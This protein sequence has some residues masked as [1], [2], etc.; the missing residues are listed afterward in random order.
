M[1]LKK[2]NYDEVKEQLAP[3]L[4][5]YD[6]QEELTHGSQC[7]LYGETAILLRIEGS[8]LVVVALAGKLAQTAKAL[9]CHALLSDHIRAIRFHT[10]RIA[11][12]RFLRSHGIPVELWE[13]RENEYVL[14][15]KCGR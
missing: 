12:Q 10:Q 5:G 2:V 8:E 13:H 6:P 4:M 3:A 9:F 1:Q 7:Y 11:E 14:G 15:V